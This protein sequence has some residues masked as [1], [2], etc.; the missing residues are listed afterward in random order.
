MNINI[1]NTLKYLHAE[2]IGGGPKADKDKSQSRKFK[3][4]KSHGVMSQAC[5]N[6][7]QMKTLLKSTN[8]VNACYRESG[9]NKTLCKANSSC[10]QNL[11]EET[12]FEK[13]N[14]VSQSR[15]GLITVC[16]TVKHLDI[17]MIKHGLERSL[18]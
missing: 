1:Q 10:S 11:H 6:D 13:K 16:H 14:F 9:K 2:S 18:K 17:E 8:P 7:D 3:S 12:T 5:T 4:Y 15:Y